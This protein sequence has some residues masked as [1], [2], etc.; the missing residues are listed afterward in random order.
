MTLSNLGS[1]VTINA[2][3][4]T[5]TFGTNIVAGSFLVESLHSTGSFKVENVGDSF[6]SPL[7]YSNALFTVSK[8]ANY[9]DITDFTSNSDAFVINIGQD[10]SINSFKSSLGLFQIDH[11]TRN[12]IMPFVYSNGSLVIHHVSINVLFSQVSNPVLCEVK[13]VLG[14]VSASSITIANDGQLLIDNVGETVV[15]PY[16]FTEGSVVISNI[17]QYVSFVEITQPKLLKFLNIGD[18]LSASQLVVGS[19]GLLEI[20]EIAG[21]VVVPRIITNGTIII[22]EVSQFLFID[23]VIGPIMFKIDDVSGF[24]SIRDIDSGV[25]GEISIENIGEHVTID[26]IHSTGPVTVQFVMSTVTFVEVIGPRNLLIN[27]INS[28]VTASR[29][30]LGS[31]PGLTVQNVLGHVTV[32]L[33]ETPGFVLISNIELFVS[34][35]T[36]TGPSEVRVRD[37]SQ[38]F[39][40][41]SISLADNGDVFIYRVSA[42]VSINSITTTGRVDIRNIQDSVIFSTITSPRIFYVANIQGVLCIDS[43][44]IRDDGSFSVYN[45]QEEVEIPIISGHRPAIVM[46]DIGNH[47]YFDDVSFPRSLRLLSIGH[48]IIITTVS[49]SDDTNSNL[50]IRNI[51]NEVAIT[52]I[53]TK[54]SVL[55]RYVTEFVS[56]S[57][58]TAPIKFELLNIQQY[59]TINDVSLADDSEFTISDIGQSVTISTISTTGSISVS[60]IG[61]FVSFVDVSYPSSL[62]INDVSEHFTAN[63][64]LVSHLGVVEIDTIGE[65]ITI[66]L[67][68]T[69]GTLVISNV[70]EFVTLTDVTSLESIHVDS[71]VKSLSASTIEL[72]TASVLHMNDIGGSITVTSVLTGGDVSLSNVVDSVTVTNLLSP[73]HFTMFNV[74]SFTSDQVTISKSCNISEVKNSFTVNSLNTVG[75][76]LLNLVDDSV[77]INSFVSVGSSTLSNI[78]D[79][80]T[81]PWF[82]S[83]GNSTLSTIDGQFTIDTLHCVGLSVND[84]GSSCIINQFVVLV[85]ATLQNIANEFTVNSL[86]SLGS[87]SDSSFSLANVGGFVSIQEVYSV[88]PFSID[89]VSH[90]VTIEVILSKNSFDLKNIGQI[91]QSSSITSFDSWSLFT[92]STVLVTEFSQHN[93]SGEMLFSAIESVTMNLVTIHSGQAEFL[94]VDFLNVT[95]WTLEDSHDCPIVLN[96]TSLK[97]GDI[98]FI[99]I[100]YPSSVHLSTISEDLLLPELDITGKLAISDLEFP[101]ILSRVRLSYRA[102]LMLDTTQD[103]T[104]TE[105]F[106]IYDNSTRG[107][108]D[109]VIVQQDSVFSGGSITDGI[110]EF[111]AQVQFTSLD[112]KTLQDGGQITLNHDSIF[113]DGAFLLTSTPDKQHISLFFGDGAVLKVKD[114]VTLDILNPISFVQLPYSSTRG[115]ILLGASSQLLLHYTASFE[116]FVSGSTFFNLLSGSLSFFGGS[117]FASTNF[118]TKATSTTLDGKCFSSSSEIYCVSPLTYT[119]DNDSHLRFNKSSLI[120]TRASSTEFSGNYDLTANYTHEAGFVHFI[121][122]NQIDISLITMLS[123]E[124]LFTRSISSLG[125]NQFFYLHSYGGQIEMQSLTF[126]AIDDVMLSSGHLSIFDSTSASGPL[127]FPIVTLEYSS[128]LLLERSTSTIHSFEIT[129][130]ITTI[131]SEPLIIEDSFLFGNGQICIDNTTLVIQE[132]AS[133]TFLPVGSK[134]VCANSY[135][136]LSGNLL[137]DTSQNFAGECGVVLE[138]SSVASISFLQPSTWTNNCPTGLYPQLLIVSEISTLNV[139]HNFDMYWNISTVGDV[140]I[141]DGSVFRV[142]GGG[143]FDSDVFI[144]DTCNF[145]LYNGVFLFPSNSI[146]RTMPN[147]GGT[148]VIADGSSVLFEGLYLLNSDLVLGSGFLHFMNGS[149]F[150]VTSITV[151]SGGTLKFSQ[152]PST[153][154]FN[155]SSL[156]VSGTVDFDSPNCNIFIESLYVYGGTLTFGNVSGSVTILTSSIT[157]GVVTFDSVTEDLYYPVLNSFNSTMSFGKLFANLYCE[158]LSGHHSDISFKSINDRMDL[159]FVN[160]TNS[161]LSLGDVKGYLNVTAH[162]STDSSISVNSIASW[163]VFDSVSMHGGSY[164]INTISETF[165]VNKF[166]TDKADFSIQQLGSDFF[167][168]SLTAKSGSHNY[169]ILGS[170]F[171]INSLLFDDVQFDILSIA[172]HFDVTDFSASSST[173]NVGVIGEYMN[174]LD[175]L[176]SDSQFTVNSGTGS[177]VFVQKFV[178]NKGTIDLGTINGTFISHT[179][180]FDDVSLSINQMVYFNVSELSLKQS[181]VNFGGIEEFF[182]SRDMSVISSHFSSGTGIGSYLLLTV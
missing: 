23:D 104:I 66:P 84:L 142:F 145:G 69:S 2:M 33:I 27:A 51:G 78:K 181:T 81:I 56:F 131:R 90:S 8:V 24:V 138:V 44:S 96:I 31:S 155:L 21:S 15:V 126:L 36:F 19:S 35:D 124:L 46:S 65:S 132:E 171:D 85:S 62:L 45:V 110:V 76:F 162:H 63:S 114:G 98:S 16:I 157:D 61:E 25:D 115:S 123:G 95:S 143:F 86:Q 29:F 9:F 116:P 58:V 182:W 149:V 112:T 75:E 73:V 74:F 133:W 122:S 165:S 41:L 12:V 28:N 141:V 17:A 53:M 105:F 80:L 176:L 158:S 47:V 180:S 99:D 70:G 60:K 102:Q 108:K 166:S 150:N 140:V 118:S 77:S 137:M 101:L 130:G 92:A 91:F 178:A 179:V 42:L 168:D 49:M 38:Y 4:S 173:V 1:N 20:D 3:L 152:C 82:N 127:H 164:S 34:V 139:T 67:I 172:G 54:G 167:I 55:V 174:S 151:P 79:S 154:S 7:V 64:L 144:C 52:S 13:H 88:A 87:S 59:L 146:L 57:Q 129:D 175:F 26:T 83:T 10:V 109:H 43:V 30:T 136:L 22:S 18:D 134:S 37:V 120:T 106:N 72:G 177:H 94:N 153:G 48:N 107:G 103:V 93:C 6:Q 160:L 121:D 5:G 11:V 68:S 71:V 135:I 100:L 125:V 119:F 128:R 148:V 32:P 111:L 147:L 161:Q 50:E 39:A 170:N 40:C 89:D 156:S 169:G 14:N 163:A 113:S 117:S 97:I 159:T